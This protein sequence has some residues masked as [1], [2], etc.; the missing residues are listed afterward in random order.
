MI[1]PGRKLLHY[2][3]TAALGHGGMGEVYR[4]EDT[5]LGREV[6]IKV[7]PQALAAD[8]ERM[9]RFEREAR[10]L[11]ALDHPGIAAIYGLEH[12][13]GRQC[14]VMQLV[15]GET[16]EERMKRSSVSASD[17]L[18]MP[19]ALDIAAQIAEALEAAHEKGIIHR[20]LKPAN[21]KL[22]AG[23]TPTVK[24]LDFGLARALDT[25]SGSGSAQDQTHSPTLT[26]AGTAIGV[27]LGTAAY[28][29]PE[30]AAG[31]PVDRRCDIWSFGVVL[32]EM[33]S[34]RRLFHGETVSHTL[35][36]VLRA[37][38]DFG[39][40]PASVPRS[41]RTLLE[42]CL[43]RN[44]KRRLR[45]IGEARI[46]LRDTL[47]EP[48]KLERGDEPP[49][50]SR[51]S[52]LP[53]AVAVVALA[54]AA[55]A[56][57]PRVFE[58]H[59]PPRKPRR[60]TIKGLGAPAAYRT[61]P[62][63]TMAISP[64]G[65]TL[66]VR[67]FSGAEDTLYIRALGDTVTRPVT[68]TGR[69]P[70][71][72]PDGKWLGYVSART[73]YKVN[74][75]GGSPIKI[76]EIRTVL[77]GASWSDDGHIYYATS[78]TI[79]RMP[80]SGGSAEKVVE[81]D[82]QLGEQWL[83]RP[84]AL[85]GGRG[86]LFD[87]RTGVRGVFNLWALDSRTGKRKNLGLAGTYATYVPTGHLLYVSQ[88]VVF[89]VPFD[90]DALEPSGE[91]TA[92]PEKVR[93]TPQLD[94]AVGADGTLA[95]VPASD[96]K[97]RIVTVDRH[98]SVRPL[99][100]NEL[101]F[102]S[103]GDPRFSPDGKRIVLQANGIWILDLETGIPTLVA[104]DGFYPVWSPDGRT[105]AYGVTQAESYDLYTRRADLSSPQA[106]LLDLPNNLRCAAWSR[107]GDL[108]FREEIPDRGMDL[109]MLPQT[110]F[111]DPSQAVRTLLDGPDDEI[112]PAISPDG[113]F[114]AFVTSQSGRD[115]VYVTSFPKPSGLTQVSLNGGSGPAWS[116]NG[117]ELYYVEGPAMVAVQVTTQPE[118]HVRGRQI[119]FSGNYFQYRWQRQYDVNP[120]TGEFVMVES[121]PGGADVE[122][123]LDWFTELNEI[124][125]V[126][127]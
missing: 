106:L 19:A 85:P 51:R 114:L 100:A 67:G 52:F 80:E 103:M 78:G 11:A 42:R 123:V 45:D 87:A 34:G 108:I 127:R 38:L 40:L 10:I 107:S 82:R 84:F 90:L 81:P 91:P 70:F 88:K 25:T 65:M 36:D 28:M 9:A 4:A 64:D 54:V 57:V 5:K 37:P 22:G 2:R 44:G 72:S 121:P 48:A 75:T 23:P 29:S 98:G 17:A 86:I 113:R 8:P 76:G 14:L 16:L 26:S 101:P 31:Q 50:P 124:A 102:D 6:A 53:W 83:L 125:P 105:L 3:I 56:F 73:L 95:Y 49:A 13:E 109:R 1:E 55:S 111:G 93:G 47:A 15:E 99:V 62:A 68:K 60:F 66:V 110:A 20:D 46:L 35:A 97:P 58:P 43:E 61:D 117:K 89:A 21:I 118:F 41:V 115:E 94:L 27:I 77:N 119:L 12:V 59:A 24:L 33:L 122:I 96:A 30:Q 18:S 126:R 79:F 116:P 32:F 7:L 120:V 63:A 74:L 39:L 112:A 104:E 69:A 92:L 71:F